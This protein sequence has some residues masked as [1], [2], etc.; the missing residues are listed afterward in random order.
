MG[1]ETTTQQTV[2]QQKKKDQ[3]DP[4]AYI[5]RGDTYGLSACLIFWHIWSISYTFDNLQL[6]FLTTNILS[7]LL[8]KQYVH[9]KYYLLPLNKICRYSVSY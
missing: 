8:I 4:C 6:Y 5:Q 1:Q 3:Q 2:H 9:L 7:K